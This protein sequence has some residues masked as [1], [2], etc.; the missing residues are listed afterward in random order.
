MK[1]DGSRGENWLIWD[2]ECGLCRRSVEWVRAHSGEDAFRITPYQTCPSPP[3]TPQLRADAERSVQVLTSDGQRLSGGRAVLFILRTV[4]WHPRLVAICAHPPLIW[5]V[6]LGYQVVARN[7][8][9]FSRLLARLER[10]R[11]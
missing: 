2:G 6:E 7:R 11:M 5:A 3:M 1:D 10:M 8:P 4:G 9:F